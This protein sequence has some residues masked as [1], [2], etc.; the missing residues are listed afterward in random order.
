M[1]KPLAVSYEIQPLSHHQ[2]V[3]LLGIYARK[4]KTCPQ[5]D[6]YNVFIVHF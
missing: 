5:E 3:P 1:G 4:I 6:V 2:T